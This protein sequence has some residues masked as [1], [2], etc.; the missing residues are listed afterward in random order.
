RSLAM[1][2]IPSL[3][4]TRADFEDQAF[5]INATLKNTEPLTALIIPQLS[6]PEGATMQARFSSA[7]RLANMNILIPQISYGNIHAA[8]LIMDE[9]A[10]GDTLRLAITSDRISID[11]SLYIDNV[12]LSNT[13][14]YDSL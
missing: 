1:R 10:F 13:L 7:D 9:T 3:G 8:R 11:D 14:S 6:L 5:T 12:N 4:F 2:Y